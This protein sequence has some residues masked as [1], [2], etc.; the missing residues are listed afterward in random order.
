MEGVEGMNYQ[1]LEPNSHCLQRFV[2]FP[3]FLSQVTTT[4]PIMSKHLIAF[5]WSTVVKRWGS[6][7]LVDFHQLLE[8]Q[9][10]TR[11]E[12][13]IWWWVVKQALVVIAHFFVKRVSFSSDLMKERGYMYTWCAYV[14]QLLRHLWSDFDNLF[15]RVHYWVGPIF[16]MSGSTPL[17]GHW[18]NT[19][20][21]II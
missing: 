1:L 6:R 12:R 17:S 13:C 2:N 19:Q 10:W 21:L 8:I 4:L 3:T 5:V 14:H 18:G 20:I 16:T 7:S 9:G 11:F 15:R